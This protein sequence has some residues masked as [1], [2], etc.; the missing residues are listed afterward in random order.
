MGT[1]FTPPSDA[2]VED[3]IQFTP[4]SDA[5]PEKKKDF[6]DLV[7]QNPTDFSPLKQQ[8]SESNTQPQPISLNG[9]GDVGTT[10]SVSGQEPPSTSKTDL[11]TAGTYDITPIPVKP[12]KV[13]VL[14]YQRQ[15]ADLFKNKDLQ[16]AVSVLNDGISVATG[17]EKAKLLK[18]RMNVWDELGKTKSKADFWIGQIKGEQDHSETDAQ[19]FREKSFKDYMEYGKITGDFFLNKGEKPLETVLPGVNIGTI[20]ENVIGGVLEGGDKVATGLAQATGGMPAEN[21]DQLAHPKTTMAKGVLS[22][23]AGAMQSAFGV[24]MN[25]RPEGILF[26]AATETANKIIPGAEEA[27]QLLFAPVSTLFEPKTQAGKD[28]ASILDPIPSMILMHMASKGSPK[29]E[30]LN[31]K[32]KNNE[33]FTQQDA[34]D[35]TSEITKFAED[36]EAVKQVADQAG[37]NVKTDEQIKKENGG[38]EQLN[39]KVEP[40]QQIIEAINTNKPFKSILA[41]SSVPKDEFVAKMDQAKFNGDLTDQQVNIAKAEY[42]KM[43]EVKKTLPDEYK[44]NSFII[45]LV[46]QKNELNKQK[47]IVDDA[48]HPKIE[49][50]IEEINN[51]IQEAIGETKVEPKTTEVLVNPSVVASDV[52]KE[53]TQNVPATTENTSAENVKSEVSTIKNEPSPTVSKDDFVKQHVDEIV[54]SGELSSSVPL[55]TYKQYFRNYYDRLNVN[56]TTSKENGTRTIVEG[57]N[58]SVENNPVQSGDGGGQSVLPE[59]TGGGGAEVKGGE[60]SKEDRIIEAHNKTD[61]YIQEAQ[62]LYDEAQDKRQKYIK[63]NGYPV[64][65]NATYDK[66]VSAKVEAED[67]LNRLKKAKEN[68]LPLP[69]KTELK[70]N[71]KILSEAHPK[72]SIDFAH[73]MIDDGLFHSTGNVYERRPDLGLSTAEVNKGIA[74]IKAGKNTAPAKHLI[75]KL[76]EIKDKGE[77]PMIQGNGGQTKRLGI[78]LKELRE[79]NVNNDIPQE[80][81]EA[82]VSEATKTK[83]T[84]AIDKEGINLSNIDDFAKENDWLYSPEEIKQIKDYLNETEKQTGGDLPPSVAVE[85]KGKEV[86][87][88]TKTEEP[89]LAEPTGAKPEEVT[90]PDNRVVGISREIM[91]KERIDKGLTT[92]EKQLFQSSSDKQAWENVKEKVSKN[93]E[94][95]KQRVTDVFSEVAKGEKPK[96]SDEDALIGLHERVKLRVEHNELSDQLVKARESGDNLNLID[97]ELKREQLENRQKENDQYVELVTSTGGKLLRSAGFLSGQDYSFAGLTRAIEREQG[98]E[99]TPKQKEFYRDISE[100]HE[101]L[102]REMADLQTRIKTEQ[103]IRDK[104][105]AE[106]RKKFEDELIAK[107]RKEFE[108]TGKT[109]KPKRDLKIVKEELDRARAQFRKDMQGLSSGG[110]QALGSFTDVVRLAIEYGIRNAAEFYKE[111]KDDLKGYSESEVNQAYENVSKNINN[112]EFNNLTKKAIEKSGGELHEGMKR[113]IDKMLKSVVED[114]ILELTNEGISKGLSGKELDN[115]INDNI[116]DYHIE[117]TNKIFNSL[118][119]GIPDLQKEDVRDLI[120]GYGKYKILNKD[121]VHTTI[122]EI[123]TQNRLDAALEAVKQKNELPLRTGMERHAKTQETREKEAEIIK[124]IKDKGLEPK[125]TDADIEAQYKSAEASYQKKLENAI[126]DIKKEISTGK[127]KEKSE[128]RKYDSDRIKQLQSDLEKLKAIREEKFNV[129]ENAKIKATEKAI[130]DIEKEIDGLKNSKLPKGEPTVKTVAGKQQFSFKEKKAEKIT[131]DRIKEL[132]SL[133]DALKDEKSNLIPDE[134]KKQAIISKERANRQRRYDFLEKQIK[135]NNFSPKPIPEPKP[136]DRQV[137]EVNLKIKKLEGIVAYEKNKIAQEGRGKVANAIDNLTKLQRFMIF[138]N[139]WGMGRLAYAAMFRPIMKIPNE[140]AK[141]TLSQLPVTKNIMEKSPAMYRPTIG[142]SIRATSKYY[143]ALTPL[144]RLGRKTFKD[145]LSE[146]NRRSNYSL[147]NDAVTEDRFG[148]IVG[149]ILS[150]P[151]QTHGFMKAFPKISAHES[152]YQV[153]LENLSKTTDSRTGKLYD[154][155]DP[156]VRQ[157]AIEEATREAYSDV[158]MDSAELSR[159]TSAFLTTIG[160]SENLALQAGALYAKQLLPVIKVP[161]NFYHEV[162]QQ[163]P[164]VGMLDAAQI[165]ARSGEKGANKLNNGTYRGTKNLTPEQAHKAARALVNQG[166]GAMGIGIGIALYNKYGDDIVKKIEDYKYWIHNTALPL[167]MMGIKMAKDK[168]HEE[169]MLVTGAKEAAYTGFE[170]GMKLPQVKAIESTTNTLYSIGRAFSAKEGKAK[171]EWDKASKKAKEMLATLLI[172]SGAS[173]LAKRMDDAANRDPETFKEILE[174]RIPGLRDNVPLKYKKSNLTLGGH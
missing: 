12:T 7:E 15:A 22:A 34:V 3:K 60:I 4:P 73:E 138:L 148:G 16:G 10:S 29:A 65:E 55:E 85:S 14:P 5:I 142:S 168:K 68:L 86:A 74:D 101:A 111:F 20:A 51:K 52:A 113:T 105:Q 163:I 26:N 116:K 89:P 165:V 28:V 171:E 58:Q 104:N 71:S 151:E 63:E 80:I 30:A 126:A 61:K 1:K 54:N 137:E 62:K 106:D 43:D 110:L 135:D 40:T 108:S 82:Q 84:E 42:D 94:L 107:I 164:V 70:P 53:N 2:V 59:G 129:K 140:L 90:V 38:L 103:D 39:P 36:K 174:M 47:E 100:K 23:A 123:K 79:S 44:N 109:I 119:D 131:S 166:M 130:A 78:T 9:S 139:P 122:R 146:Y 117:A 6:S 144:T 19:F 32:I 145:A 88:P 132:E 13:D 170:E 41:E 125:L 150:A 91:D 156:T 56:K 57:S 153:A 143:E 167:V 95:Y 96:V 115:Y 48:F 124:T 66:L 87:Q 136:Y 157:I 81:T 18:Q 11:P 99:L 169:S 49:A 121:Q 93:P 76:N 17:A 31:E 127:L 77:I 46:E 155:T 64:G 158:F 154:I 160:N 8:P 83:I 159:A 173:E 98:K 27:S 33:P 162:L 69:V 37:V 152:T 112:E 35:Y 72:E 75:E 92:Q 120:S 97:L 149:Q 172:P 50:K 45:D 161:V 128:P 114:K 118:K 134:I 133:R 67:R 141:Y 25:T 102:T 147:L 24:I 21:F